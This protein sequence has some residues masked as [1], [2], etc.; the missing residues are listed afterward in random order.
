M[1][2]AGNWILALAM[3]AGGA[4]ACDSTKVVDPLTRGQ[5]IGV[6]RELWDL[7][8]WVD[9]GTNMERCPLGGGATITYKE[10]YRESADT[11]W[12]S[13]HWVIAPDRCEIKTVGDTLLLEGDSSVVFKSEFRYTGFFEDGEY[14]LMGTG[15]VTWRR[16]DGSSGRCEV[17]VAVED[18]ETD[19]E[20]GGIDGDLTGRLCGFEVTIH[21]SELD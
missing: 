14:D 3:G 8:D 20:T 12:L 4:L 2:R 18:A 17:D 10:D 13:G 11:V 7:T 6:L 15:A 16:S 1:K 9:E 5:A 19:P 21:F